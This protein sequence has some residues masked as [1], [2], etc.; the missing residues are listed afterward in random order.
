MSGL[1]INASSQFLDFWSHSP[2]T[3]LFRA[4]DC[5]DNNFH[6]VLFTLAGVCSMIGSITCQLGYVSFAISSVVVL[7][8]YAFLNND[9]SRRRFW[10]SSL[11]IG[12][13][14]SL[15]RLSQAP[16]SME[17]CQIRN[18][19]IPRND[20]ST[21][22]EFAFQMCVQHKYSFSGHTSYKHLQSSRLVLFYDP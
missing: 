5:D 19:R 20:S 4:K 11:V 8:G 14:F 13:G 2:W 17:Y 18:T 10:L 16:I 7:V 22:I 15:I 3:K 9:K 1:E 12:I 21:D 6:L